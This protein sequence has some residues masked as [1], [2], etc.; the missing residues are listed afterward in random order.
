MSVLIAPDQHWALWAVLIGAAAFGVWAERTSWGA[1][2]SGAVLAIGFTFVLSNLRVIPVDAPAY[3]VVWSYFV[4]LAIPLLLLNADM[5][6]VIR[7][8][9]PTLFAFAAG[10][11]GTVIGTLAAF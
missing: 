2:L 8:S 5:K 4:P 9:G 10:A 1:R 7:E 3:G 6:R 11:V